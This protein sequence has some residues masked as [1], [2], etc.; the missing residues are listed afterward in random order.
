MYSEGKV[1]GCYIRT[2][3]R[4]QQEIKAV[5]PSTLW[6]MCAVPISVI[7]CSS[8]TNGW[9]ASNWSFWSNPSLMVPNISGTIFVLPFHILPTSSFRSLYLYSFS[10]FLELTFESPGMAIVISRQVFS[11]L[12]CSTISVQFASIVWSVINGMPN[13][14]AISLTF[15]TLSGMFIVLVS[16]L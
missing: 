5:Y 14:I 10:V 16:N 12:S 13:I 9:P 2:L 11:F 15:T 4:S 3:S 7:H 8:L 1:R 6:M